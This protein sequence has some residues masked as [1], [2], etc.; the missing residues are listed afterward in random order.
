MSGGAGVCETDLAGVCEVCLD[1][2]LVVRPRQAPLV[3]LVPLWVHVQ[4]TSAKY[5][6]GMKDGVV[7]H[8]RPLPDE[9]FHEPITVHQ[10]VQPAAHR[11]Q[12]VSV[13]GHHGDLFGWRQVGEDTV[14]NLLLGERFTDGIID[15]P[16]ATGSEGRLADVV[17]GF[18]ALH[19]RPMRDESHEAQKAGRW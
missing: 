8:L 13:D 1:E 3:L 7:T 2:G 4:S 15:E 18:L 10:P 5:G 9:Q 14:A 12:D 19:R 17:L 6:P 16:V 11:S